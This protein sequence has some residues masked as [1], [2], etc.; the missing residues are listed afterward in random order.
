MSIYKGKWN[1]DV[2]PESQD[3]EKIAILFSGLTIDAIQYQHQEF[4]PYHLRN[5]L[6]TFHKSE[7]KSF[8]ILFSVK[9]SP[10]FKLSLQKPLKFY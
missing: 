8:V 2:K 1:P 6:F 5:Y 4:Q 3:T 9:S 10:T 7:T